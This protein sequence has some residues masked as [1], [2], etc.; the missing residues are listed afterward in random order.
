[1]PRLGRGCA[2]TRAAQPRA[3]DRAGGGRRSSTRRGPGSHPA[4]E[5][6]GS[7]L[8]GA[9]IAGGA[10]RRGRACGARCRLRLRRLPG[11]RRSLRRRPCRCRCRPRTCRDAPGPGDLR[12]AATRRIRKGPRVPAAPPDRSCP[13]RRRTPAAASSG[14]PVPRPRPLPPLRRLLSKPMRRGSRSFDA[15]RGL[16]WIRRG[17]GSRSRRTRCGR[18][19]ADGDEGWNW[20][21]ARGRWPTAD[22]RRPG[23]VRAG[24][25]GGGIIGSPPLRSRRRRCRRGPHLRAAL[26]D[27]APRTARGLGRLPDPGPAGPRAVGVHALAAAGGC[28][29][30]RWRH[31]TASRRRPLTCRSAARWG[32]TGKGGSAQG[33]KKS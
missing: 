17:S 28:K 15:L 16:D 25:G 19:V 8:R 20:R 12:A 4:G 33:R 1:M 10:S 2:G 13:P 7:P 23:A 22:A 26:A 3:L 6:A 30:S 11:R 27:P 31:H 32:R 14:C 5:G 18:S 29:A 9:A 24:R 21:I